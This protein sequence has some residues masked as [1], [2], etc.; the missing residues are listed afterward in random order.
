MGCCVWLLEMTVLFIF[1]L[2]MVPVSCA[3]TLSMSALGVEMHTFKR[4]V[5]GFLVV[6]RPSCL[7]FPLGDVRSDSPCCKIKVWN[8]FRSARRLSLRGLLRF[9]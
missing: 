8:S 2:F 9:R 3:C 7:L 4:N 6:S 1:W 5:D